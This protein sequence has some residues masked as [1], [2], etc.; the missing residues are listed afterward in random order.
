[1][2]Y[3]HLG[4]PT[5]KLSMK[6]QKIGWLILAIASIS[7]PQWKHAREMVADIGHR[8][9]SEGA[10][11]SALEHKK[12]ASPYSKRQ[13][14]LLSTTPPSRSSFSFSSST[15][16]HNHP[17][18]YGAFCTFDIFYCRSPLFVLFMFL[19]GTTLGHPPLFLPWLGRR[20]P[21]AKYRVHSRAKFT[22]YGY[23]RSTDH[24]IFR[25]ICSRCK[26]AAILKRY[27]PARRRKLNTRGVSLP[28]N[29]KRIFLSA[30]GEKQV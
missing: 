25:R 13:P 29:A 26:R 30:K 1:M 14:P 15:S 10:K 28:L 2:G 22:P 18:I 27:I 24:W 3:S 23:G 5:Y 8:Y 7:N 9:I 6:G 20:P 16:V 17:P 4:K 21:P 11:G 12:I 19:L